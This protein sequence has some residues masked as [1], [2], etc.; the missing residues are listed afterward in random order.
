MQNRQGNMLASLRTAR[1]FL[2]AHKAELPNTAV[3]GARKKLD[4]AIAD[5]ATHL[6]DQTGG[7]VNHRLG[8]K[9][10]HALRVALLR[11]NMA[12]ISQ[13]AKVSFSGIQDLTP[14]RTPRGTPTTERL[15]VAARGMA[16]AAEPH[17]A[18]F[19]SDGMPAD[20][21]ARLNAAADALLAAKDARAGVHGK[22]SGANAGV[23]KRLREGRQAIGTLNLLVRVELAGDPILLSN[24]NTIK[25]LPHAKVSSAT[26]AGVGTPS[27]VV[28]SIA[29]AP[30]T[31]PTTT[32]A[33]PPV[34]S[35]APATP[36]VA[37]TAPAT[38]A[39]PATPTPT[40]SAAHA[41]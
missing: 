12:L 8:T 38:P 37:T 19:I 36:P 33:T 21:I 34:V 2:D 30:A 27:P 4:A 24:W 26:A 3:S 1:D 11:D 32:P 10:V 15:V 17:A 35:S 13:I 41:A 7:T 16:V 28:G 25:R 23:T 39:A 14:L 22:T 5:L 9:T 29:P 31:V 6:A 18:V 20:F 40:V